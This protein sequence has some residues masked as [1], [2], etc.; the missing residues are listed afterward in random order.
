[1]N[2]TP[3]RADPA[4]FL[5]CEESSFLDRQVRNTGRYA[6]VTGVDLCVAVTLSIW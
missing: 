4:E 1:M 2:V 5:N 6:V 3:T